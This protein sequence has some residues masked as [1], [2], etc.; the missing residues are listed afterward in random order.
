MARY[1][2]SPR[3]V[4]SIYGQIGG[5]AFVNGDGG[6]RKI[7]VL[8]TMVMTEILEHQVHCSDSVVEQ[9]PEVLHLH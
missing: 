8:V 3:Y 2:P 7:S 5:S 4:N 1:R 9:N 6:T